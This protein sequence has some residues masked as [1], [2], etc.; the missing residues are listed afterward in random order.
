MR[1]EIIIISIVAVVGVLVLLVLPRVVVNNQETPSQTAQVPTESDTHDHDEEDG[2]VAGPHAFE[3]DE[4]TMTR[5]AHLR[6]NYLT[7]T[8]TQKKI[9]FADSLSKLFAQLN[10]FDSA[11]VY[12]ERLAELDPTDTNLIAA[13][14]W[15]SEAF[16][17]S[18]EPAHAEPLNQKAQSI[19]RRVLERSPDNLDV[20]A[21]LAMTYMSSNTPMEGILMLRGILEQDPENQTALYN[22][23]VLALQTRQYDRAI[24]RFQKLIE[25]NPQH[26]QGYFYLGVSHKELGHRKEARLYFEKVK[27]LSAD[28]AVQS[29][30]EDYLRELS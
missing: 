27:E 15:Y 17:L 29:T 3:A 19:Y 7:E 25:I 1:K 9:I 30:V 10:R 22:L 20:K 14:D 21:K 12:Q 5:L 24:E 18:T 16:N 8:N 4:V 6:T 28:P 26:M 11:A 2:A 13:A 23:G